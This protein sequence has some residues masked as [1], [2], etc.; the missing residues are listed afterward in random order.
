MN[1]K[2]KIKKLIR[3]FYYAFF[4]KNPYVYFG[5]CI[6]PFLSENQKDKILEKSSL[7]FDKNFIEISYQ[8]FF[9][10]RFYRLNDHKKNILN[11]K[12]LWGN[13]FGKNWHKYHE[14]ET[15]KKPDRVYFKNKYIKPWI[16][17]LIKEKK[18]EN[19]IEIGTGLGL[20]LLEIIKENDNNNINFFGIDLNKDCVSEAEK[21]SKGISNCKFINSNCLDFIENF[22]NSKTIFFT[23]G[24]ME[25]MPESDI[26]KLF[27]LISTRK[28]TYLIMSEPVNIN[29][30]CDFKSNPRG[31]FAYS[32]NYLYAAKLSN[33][34]IEKEE[35]HLSNEKL[36]LRNVNLLLCAN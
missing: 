36:N 12:K 11:Y 27:N 5:Y 8:L 22:R 28:E 18:I 4:K 29:L 2:S 20:L 21:R 3:N 26:Y 1:L 15:L 13:T 6:S 33:L 7:P 34:K 10:D 14:A 32:H 17:E 23:S 24:T 19:I 31:G 25:Y 30:E 9:E 16:F 35:I